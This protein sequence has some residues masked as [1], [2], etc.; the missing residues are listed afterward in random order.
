MP[1]VGPEP[2]LFHRGFNARQRI[3]AQAQNEPHLAVFMTLR[4]A[5]PGK[6]CR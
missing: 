1:K 2:N 3:I 6:E 5:P 4:S